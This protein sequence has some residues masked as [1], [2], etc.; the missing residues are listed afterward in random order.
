MQS[1][2]TGGLTPLLTVNQVAELTK[3]RPGSIRK[4]IAQG[5]LPIVRIGRSVRVSQKVL[6]QVLE[7]GI[8]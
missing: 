8:K 4:I 5:R 6:S 3:L 2:Q 7:K 1:T